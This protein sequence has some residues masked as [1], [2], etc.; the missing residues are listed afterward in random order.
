MD[1]AFKTIVVFTSWGH[2]HTI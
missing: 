1:V 2:Y